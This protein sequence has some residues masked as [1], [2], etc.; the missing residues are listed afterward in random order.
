[1]KDYYQWIA[2]GSKAASSDRPT[3]LNL[4]PCA[5]A[6]SGV[7]TLEIE[8]ESKLIEVQEGS[9]TETFIGRLREFWHLRNGRD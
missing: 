5:L 1:M 3:R 6:P 4:Q 8:P 2:A 9:A 7:M